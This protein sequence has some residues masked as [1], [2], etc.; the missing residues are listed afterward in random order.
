MTRP[1]RN[2]QS[3]EKKYK[4]SREQNLDRDRHDVAPTF[5]GIPGGMREAHLLVLPPAILRV[6]GPRGGVL[7]HDKP[8]AAARLGKGARWLGSAAGRWSAGIRGGAQGLGACSWNHLG[9]TSS[10]R[11]GGVS[12]RMVSSSASKVWGHGRVPSR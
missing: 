3:P 12:Q 4:V 8:V 11:S 5:A 2:R 7:R 10:S 9:C 1:D 6:R